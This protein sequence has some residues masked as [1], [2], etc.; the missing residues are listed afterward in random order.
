MNW[1]GFLLE[2]LNYYSTGKLIAEKS[3]L[4]MFQAVGEIILELSF[5][6]NKS[7]KWIL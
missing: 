7:K 5:C 6:C 4:E 1:F 2:Y 3:K